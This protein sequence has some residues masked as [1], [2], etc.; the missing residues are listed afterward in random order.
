MTP[1]NRPISPNRRFALAAGDLAAVKR[2]GRAAG[3]TVNDALL[4]VVAGMLG[5]YLDGRPPA[6]SRPRPVALV[7]VSVRAAPDGRERPATGSRPC[8]ST[9]RWPSPS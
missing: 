9:S 7:P 6:A 1:L 2:A 3:A 4:A 8:S 5:R